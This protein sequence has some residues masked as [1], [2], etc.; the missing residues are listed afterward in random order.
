MD[1][2]ASGGHTSRN[3]NSTDTHLGKM[4]FYWFI[5]CMKL[6]FHAILYRMCHDALS[7]LFQNA[8]FHS[9]SFQDNHNNLDFLVVE[10]K[11]LFK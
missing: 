10:H 3:N 2:N 7:L 9:S 6:S 5:L 4:L 8:E 11:Q 1:Y